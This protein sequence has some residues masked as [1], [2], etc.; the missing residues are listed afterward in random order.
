[1]HD[2]TVFDPEAQTRRELAEVRRQERLPPLA[3][4]K[5]GLRKQ[6]TAELGSEYFANRRGPTTTKADGL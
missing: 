3:G 5:T 1:L 2:S 4:L 6:V